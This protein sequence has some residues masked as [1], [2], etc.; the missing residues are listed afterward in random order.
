[1]FG[2][3]LFESTLTVRKKKCELVV[4]SCK[5]KKRFHHFHCILNHRIIDLSID[6]DGNWI[7]LPNKPTQL[8]EL[9]GRK[10]ESKGK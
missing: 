7:E 2:V 5:E 4:Y 1:M 8:A 9:I 6:K 3:L 10:I